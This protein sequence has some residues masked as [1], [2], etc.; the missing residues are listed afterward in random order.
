VWGFPVVRSVWSVNVVEALPH[1][2]LLLEIHVVAIREQLVE[3]V[4][5]G[6]V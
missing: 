6:S 1:G 4:L 3:L 5:M 2:E